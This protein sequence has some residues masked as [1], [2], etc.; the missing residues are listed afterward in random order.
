MTLDDVQS[1]PDLRGI[2]IDEAGVSGLRYPVVVRDRRGIAQST[3]GTF[4]VSVSVPETVKGTHM[5]RFVEIV[6]EHA[7]DIGAATMASLVDEVRT[8]LDASRAHVSVSATYFRERLAPATGARA[9]LGCDVVW[10]ATCDGDESRVELGVDVPVTS[11]CPCSKEIS[12]Y[13]AHNQRGHV[14]VRAR[15]AAAAER[16]WV[17]DLIDVAESV[18]S[19]PVYP[20]LKRPDERYVTMQ[21]YDNPVF[22]E[23]MARDVAQEL[24]KDSRV[25]SFQVRVVNDESIH[26]HAAFAS[27]SWPAQAGV[28][29]VRWDGR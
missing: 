18:G 24:R 21:A 12:D 28:G 17:E 23:D 14:I 26:D 20:L 13:G 1:R 3:V 4:A 27:I 11:L 19:A 7:Q 29:L 6:H 9:L 16:L 22:V 10:S 5:S 8:R 2:A 25:E 15:Q